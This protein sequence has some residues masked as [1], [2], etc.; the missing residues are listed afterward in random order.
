MDKWQLKS[1]NYTTTL[2]TTNCLYT[3]IGTVFAPSLMGSAALKALTTTTPT[4]PC[5]ALG[6]S[7]RELHEFQVHVLTGVTESCALQTAPALQGVPHTAPV[8]LLCQSISSKEHLEAH[9]LLGEHTHIPNLHC[10]CLRFCRGTGPASVLRAWSSQH[11]SPAPIQ[12]TQVP[13]HSQDPVRALQRRSCKLP[14]PPCRRQFPSEHPRIA[15]ANATGTTQYLPPQPCSELRPG[16]RLPTTAP[17]LRGLRTYRR[18]QPERHREQP[19]TAGR[20]RRQPGA[21]SSPSRLLSPRTLPQQES[22][23]GK[24]TNQN[25]KVVS[26]PLRK[27]QL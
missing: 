4:K 5:I 21:P 15:L 11:R 24:Q 1:T 3:Y 26:A 10:S 17:T 13:Q 19:P 22:F 2:T 20:G 8:L 16:C 12:G 7:P 18:R 6:N 23:S 25:A 14:L 9:L 27:P